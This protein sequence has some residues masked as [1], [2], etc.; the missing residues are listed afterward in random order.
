[1]VLE[2]I[3]TVRTVTE[4]TIIKKEKICDRNAAGETF[5]GST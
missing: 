5:R 1:M 3:K 4:E 2:Y